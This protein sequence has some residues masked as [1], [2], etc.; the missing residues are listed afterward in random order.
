MRTYYMDFEE[1][2]HALINI[3]VIDD[4]VSFLQKFAY[5][6]LQEKWPEIGVLLNVFTHIWFYDNKSLPPIAVE[7]YPAGT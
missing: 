6:A 5:F 3:D 7:K 4:A 1:H 2:I